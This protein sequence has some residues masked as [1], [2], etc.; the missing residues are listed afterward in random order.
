[1]ADYNRDVNV[2]LLTVNNCTDDVTYLQGSGTSYSTYNFS[3]GCTGSVSIAT[4]DISGDLLS[5]LAVVCEGTSQ[6][7]TRRGTGANG[8]SASGASVCTALWGIATDR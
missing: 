3:T 6:M 2:D 1:A 4:G 8:N 7:C 5:D